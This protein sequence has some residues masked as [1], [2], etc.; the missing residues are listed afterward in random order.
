M[1]RVVVSVLVFTS[2]LSHGAAQVGQGAAIRRERLLE[3]ERRL[4]AS[5]LRFEQVFEQYRLFRVLLVITRDR[6]S[7]PRARSASL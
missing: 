5:S 7:A 1:N 4:S 6:S 2:V 3:L